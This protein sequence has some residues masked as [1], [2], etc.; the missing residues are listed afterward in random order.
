MRCELAVTRRSEASGL[1]LG[2]RTV[3]HVFGTVV[4]GLL[5][6][7]QDV[8]AHYSAFAYSGPNILVSLRVPPGVSL[9]L[10]WLDWNWWRLRERLGAL[11]V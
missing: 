5:H 10:V 7:A 4:E 2:V 11:G 1:T 6:R 3:K 8:V 9:V